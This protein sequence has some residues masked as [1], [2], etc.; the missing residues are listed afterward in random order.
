V[1][2]AAGFDVLVH[3]GIDT[4]ALAGE[5]FELLVRPG[6]RVAAGAPLLRFDLDLLARRAPSLVSPVVLA[7]GASVTR[8]MDNRRIAAG[9][10]LMEVMPAES[11]IGASSANE[12]VVRAF[13]IPFDH[14]LHVRP[15]AQIAA[16]LRPYGCE[17]KLSCGDRSAN[18]RSTVAMM[19]LGVR[20]GDAIEARAAGDDALEA[21]A[22]LEALFASKEPRVQ[23]P[24]ATAIDAPRR[25][26]AAIAS[27]GVALGRCMQWREA[28][29]AI[30]GTGR[31]EARE[32]E[33][34]Q[35]AIDAVVAQLESARDAASRDAQALFAAHVE[36][37][38]DPMLA[39]AALEHVRRGRSDGHAWR[40]ATRATADALLALADERMRERAADLRDIE[41]QVL[42][43][44]LGGDARDRLD[45]P[46]HAIVVADDLPPSRTA[47]LLRAG[48]HGICTARGGTTSHA[49]ILAASA[50][51]PML[52]AA[53]ADVLRIEEGARL[54]L[55]AEHGRLEVDPPESEWMAMERAIAVRAAQ[56]TADLA[57]AVEPA[58]TRDGVRILVKAN[59]GSADEAERALACGAEGCGLLRTEF[60]FLE[61]LDPPGA[62]EQS[63][64]YERIAAALAGRPLDI[65]T[66]DVGGDK[67]IAYL[68]LAAEENPAL[69]VR[70]IRASLAHPELLRTQLR[71]ILSASASHC[72]I[73]LPMVNDVDEVRAVRAMLEGIVRELHAPRVPPLGAM[74][75][76]PAAALLADS[77]A[78]AL[79]FLS[80]GTNDLAQYTLAID[81][82]HPQLG[83]R[84]DALHPAVLRLIARVADAAAARGKGASVCGALA[85]DAD[86]LPILVGLGV[87]EISATPAAIPRLK[88]VVR[89]LHAGECAALA[90]RALDE[91][92]AAAVRES[93][94]V[95]RERCRAESAAAMTGD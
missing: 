57:R 14:G 41:T 42:R 17:V 33:A 11:R 60:L 37:A 12:A 23:A 94:A 22:A 52:V 49:A 79:D 18:A 66:L 31:G 46:A 40:E 1:R 6:E 45:L 51:V 54:V 5:G 24:Q 38:R 77:L 13:V 30:E 71:A 92:T 87:R 3:V 85:S 72:R 10:L 70:G 4:V 86:A 35:A 62:D 7:S 28:E 26:E 53:G 74:I 55:D 21:L 67:P 48:V 82:A 34:L 44:L 83:P 25:V 93:S 43:A 39:E 15:A 69:G 29:I 68:P 47:M 78:E 36:L 89:T 8:R 2:H 32:R 88:A 65:R 9:E 27:R 19:S 80:I 81:R 56:R 50:G 16:A 61:R 75:E 76:T 90:R 58:V 95:F 84:L 59:L 64:G 20:R 73:L 91:P 63:A